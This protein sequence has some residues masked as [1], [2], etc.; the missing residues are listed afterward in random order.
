V[1]SKMKLP[2]TRA[3]IGVQLL[4]LPRKTY[5]NM[6]LSGLNTAT[7]IGLMGLVHRTPRGP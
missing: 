1:N 7:S 5:S 6:A 3:A 4:L 2:K